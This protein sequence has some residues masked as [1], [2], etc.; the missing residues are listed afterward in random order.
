MPHQQGR[1]HPGVGDPVAIPTATLAGRVPGR[2][3]EPGDRERQ[4]SS[5]LARLRRSSTASA[6]MA[7]ST[8]SAPSDHHDLLDS[9]GRGD[10]PGVDVDAGRQPRLRGH[11]QSVKIPPT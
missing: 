9:G 11:L 2:S 1:D 7:I 6:T 10:E 4:L 8:A 5:A 3:G